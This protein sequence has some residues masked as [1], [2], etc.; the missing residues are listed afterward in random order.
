MEH[1]DLEIRYEAD[2]TRA[3]PGRLTG[4]LLTYGERAGDRAEM[5]SRGALYWPDSGIVLNAQHNRQSPILRTLPVIDGDSLRIDA[6]LPNTTAG[7]DAAENL[8]GENPLYTGLSV[9][10]RAE[11][12]SRRGGLRV[13]ERAFMPRAALVDSPSYRGSTVEVRELRYWNL[14]REILRW[15]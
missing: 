9:E 4:T 13:I 6:A 2:E 14:D 5:F 1:L 12:E 8:R 7:R 15:L 10:F 11:R 3:T